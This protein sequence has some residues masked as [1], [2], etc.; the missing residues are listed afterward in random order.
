MT[1]SHADSI[2]KETGFQAA[3]GPL[4]VA[5]SRPSGAEAEMS[6]RADWHEWN[7]CPSQ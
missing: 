2:D 3:E 7:S 6:S 4:L 5:D 1:S